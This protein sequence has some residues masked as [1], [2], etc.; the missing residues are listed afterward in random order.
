[1]EGLVHFMYVFVR[2]V[3]GLRVSRVGF[4]AVIKSDQLYILISPGAIDLEITSGVLLGCLLYVYVLWVSSDNWS[5]VRCDHV[6]L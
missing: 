3:F 1:M 5:S 2:L 4:G 6:R